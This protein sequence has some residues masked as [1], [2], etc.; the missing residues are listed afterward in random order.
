MNLNPSTTWTYIR[1]KENRNGWENW[2]RRY[3]TNHKKS[4]PQINGVLKR[5]IMSLTGVAHLPNRKRPFNQPLKSGVAFGTS[6]QQ[7]INKLNN[8]IK[9]LNKQYAFQEKS[10]NSSRGTSSTKLIKSAD[11]IKKLLPQKKAQLQKLYKIDMQEV[12]DRQNNYNA[13]LNAMAAQ[14]RQDLRE[15]KQYYGRKGLNAL[16]IVAG[17]S[18][19]TGKS[20]A[21][22]SLRAGKSVGRVSLRA[23][24]RVA[25]ASL[26][27]GKRVAGASLRAGKRVKNRYT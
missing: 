24:K 23:G 26:R 15:L 21:G 8:I 19:R 10:A 6:T 18:L 5:A 9:Q 7:E 3:K 16:G 27:A 20:V 25:G 2:V 12:Q 1:D 11:K 14:Q 13:I 4:G 17:A 22:A